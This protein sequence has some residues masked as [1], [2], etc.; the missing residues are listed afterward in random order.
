MELLSEGLGSDI[1]SDSESGRNSFTMPRGSRAYPS[2]PPLWLSQF[3]VRSRDAQFWPSIGSG[4]GSGL[5]GLRNVILVTF[6]EA[7]WENSQERLFYARAENNSRCRGK[8]SFQHT[9]PQEFTSIIL[10]I[11]KR[12]CPP[13][14]CVTSILPYPVTFLNCPDSVGSGWIGTCKN[15]WGTLHLQL[16]SDTSSY[17]EIHQNASMTYSCRSR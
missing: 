3:Q 8:H 7:R 14:Q 5:S 16:H 10:I 15:R 9:E 6:L 11:R 1:G 12:H 13:P 2:L 17:A 4:V